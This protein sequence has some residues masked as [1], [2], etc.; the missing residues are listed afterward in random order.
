MST[1][2]RFER[3]IPELMAELAPVR[4]PDYIDDMLQQTA[5]HGQRP[6]WSFPERWLPVD[7]TA[8]PLATRSFP[9]RPLAAVALLALLLAATLI[10][11]TGSQTRLP[12][13]FGVAANGA[14]FYRAGG[15]TVSFD[16]VTAA[17]VSVPVPEGSGDP[18]LSRDGQRIAL[19]AYGFVTPTPIV[20]TG[21][22]GSRP[23]TLA[24]EY[25]EIDD[26]QWSPDGHRLAIVARDGDT[27]SITV[28]ASDGSGAKTLIRGR[29]IAEIA[30]LPDGRIAF[31]AADRAGEACP[32]A[33]QTVAPCAL[34]V[35]NADGTGLDR[36]I[37]PDAFHGINTISPSP[38]GTSIL[39]VEWDAGTGATG[40][41]HLFD[42]GKRL[43]RLVPTNGF[44]TDFAINRAW[45]S[46]DGGSILFDFFD[47]GGDY[48]AIASPDG[49]APVRIGRAWAGDSTDASWAPDGRSVLARYET[50]GTGSELWLLDATGA[51]QDRKLDVDVP[52]LPRWQRVSP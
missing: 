6:A 1:F 38:D 9:W 51:G 48:W 18:V 28:A 14:L 15:A 45:F 43:D 25:P 22:D 13:P 19:V 8:R 23:I 30:Y 35:V 2:E 3:S 29:E 50:G 37:P 41:L 26:V 39:Y 40:R 21:I 24:G 10:A 33:D 34:F 32:G 42:L 20:I 4:E 52:Y 27:S 44:P 47:S 12:P 46:P 36:L 17:R 5:R 16:P 11:Y 31:V 49:G 7:I